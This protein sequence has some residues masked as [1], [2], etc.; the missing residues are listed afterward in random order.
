MR[1][2][3]LDVSSAE[4]LPELEHEQAV[5]QHLHDIFKPILLSKNDELGFDADNPNSYLETAHI[6]P[7]PKKGDYK[8]S[9][10]YVR[11]KKRTIR[12]YILANKKSLIVRECEKLKGVKSYSI[13]ADLTKKRFSFM[14]ALITSKTFSKVWHNDGRTVKFT[15]P[16]T[17]GKVYKIKMFECTPEA[18]ISKYS[19]ALV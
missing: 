6:L 7:K 5:M 16:R 1:V 3:N 12:N 8:F 14:Q 13:S 9:P 19:N 15:L 17:G 11:F 4:G 18:L 2:N 10:I